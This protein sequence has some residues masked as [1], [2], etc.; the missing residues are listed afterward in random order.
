MFIS[1]LQYPLDAD[2]IVGRMR[3]ILFAKQHREQLGGTIHWAVAGCLDK[4]IRKENERHSTRKIKTIGKLTH[5]LRESGY[6][7]STYLSL[8][9]ET[10]IVVHMKNMDF[11][12]CRKLG[13]GI[14]VSAGDGNRN[15]PDGW[16]DTRFTRSSISEEDL[17]LLL[18]TFDEF[19]QECREK[20]Q[21]RLEKVDRQTAVGKLSLPS[22]ELTVEERLGK[23]GISYEM[24][25]GSSGNIIL[26]VQ[27]VKEIWMRHPD[28]SMENLDRLLGL[29][30]YLIKRPDC[31][32][33]DGMGFGIIHGKVL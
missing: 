20:M 11:F 22:M 25:Q 13:S 2:E 33:R 3:E 10:G 32:Q 1:T 18:E 14:S 28:V 24:R 15:N 17:V 8:E 31:I 12:I 16:R 30:P 6:P 4:A 9:R 19:M 29:V 26:D 23:R 7:V 5:L 21:A 27:I